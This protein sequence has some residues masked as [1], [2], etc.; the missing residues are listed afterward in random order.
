MAATGYT[1]LALPYDAA[2]NMCFGLGSVGCVTRMAKTLTICSYLLATLGALVTLG[3][4]PYVSS[5]LPLGLLPY[6]FFILATR[7]ARRLI[8][9]AAVL[10]LTLLSVCVG[11]WFFWDALVL[12]S[13]MAL[14]PLDIV[15]AESLSAAA[16]WLVVRR[17]DRS[18]QARRP[19]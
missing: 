2:H 5:L 19:E 7:S 12:P 14:L 17:V 11:F 9:L 6:A 18:P 10:I 8:T 4:F 16:T 15:I 3:Y 13:T 1:S